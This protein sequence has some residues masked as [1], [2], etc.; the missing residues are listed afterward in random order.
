MEGNK[1]ALYPSLL[2]LRLGGVLEVLAQMQAL[3]TGFIKYKDR[4]G[5]LIPEFG[6]DE[7]PK[8]V[9]LAQLALEAPVNVTKSTIWINL[10]KHFAY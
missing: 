2:G 9:P 5:S 3:A 8:Q 4:Y 10:L 1:N 6:A 7:D